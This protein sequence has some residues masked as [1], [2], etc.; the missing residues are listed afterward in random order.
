MLSFS[1]APPTL[2]QVPGFEKNA[3][4]RP[5]VATPK[6]SAFGVAEEGAQHAG[7]LEVET[8][9]PLAPLT[10]DLS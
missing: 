5:N 3:Q 10:T 8:K 4:G 7:N 9:S 2:T 1:A 6:A